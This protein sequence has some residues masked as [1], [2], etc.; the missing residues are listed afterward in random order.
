MA[1]ML[2]DKTAE[3]TIKP[4]GSADKTAQSKAAK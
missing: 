3:A 4:A 1:A 2:E